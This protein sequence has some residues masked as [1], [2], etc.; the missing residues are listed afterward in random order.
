MN[1]FRLTPCSLGRCAATAAVTVLL[2]TTALAQPKQNDPPTTYGNQPQQARVDDG[3]GLIR[4]LADSVTP[5][6]ANKGMSQAQREERMRSLYR[7]HFDNQA[8]AAG[9]M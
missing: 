4:S 8:I 2:A 7:A 3:S 1:R 9:V 6:I 5:V